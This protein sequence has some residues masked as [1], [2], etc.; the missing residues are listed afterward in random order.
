MTRSFQRLP[1]CT[2][3]ISKSSTGSPKSTPSVTLL[4]RAKKLK[5]PRP[6]SPNR[7]LRIYSTRHLTASFKRWMKWFPSF[8]MFICW[9]PADVPSPVPFYVLPP[10]PFSIPTCVRWDKC[11]IVTTFAILKS[12]FL[13][14]LKR[15]KMFFVSTSSR[16]ASCECVL[17][18]S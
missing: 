7:P 3:T 4:K 2:R 18:S 15:L 11:K 14:V 5:S 16:W 10:I 9:E 17:K 13:K 1:V 8:I 6:K 12:R